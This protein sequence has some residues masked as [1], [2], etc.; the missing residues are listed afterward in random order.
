MKSLKENEPPSLK[1][2]WVSIST[3]LPTCFPLWGRLTVSSH[4]LCPTPT[5]Q[6]GETPAS[7]C[8]SGE[9][10]LRSFSSSHSYAI[11]PEVLL[12]RYWAILLHFSDHILQTIFTRLVIEIQS[13]LLR[14][15]N[16]TIRISS[17]LCK[18]STILIDD[19]VFLQGLALVLP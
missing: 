16:C 9:V 2:L 10:L 18:A 4:H 15:E 8:L 3:T 17:G 12:L 19:C 6:A 5:A 13:I 14:R 7:P 11:P 1:S